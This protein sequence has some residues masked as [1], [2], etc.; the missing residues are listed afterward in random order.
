MGGRG[1]EEVGG[2]EG[3]MQIQGVLKE[4]RANY[5]RQ[6]VGGDKFKRRR[7]RWRKRSR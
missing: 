5:S 3:T 6:N 4:T 2:G 1:M 7:E